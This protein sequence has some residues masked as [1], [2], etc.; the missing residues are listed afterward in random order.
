M[1]IKVLFV[2]LTSPFQY[3]YPNKN[4]KR[5]QNETESSQNVLRYTQSSFCCDILKNGFYMVSLCQARL[6]LVVI[7]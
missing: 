4:G 7:Y 6:T 2:Q 1:Q 5:S 3:Y